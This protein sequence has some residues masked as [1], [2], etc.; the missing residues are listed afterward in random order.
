MYYELVKDIDNIMM[1][2]Q[3]C[4]QSI[5]QFNIIISFNLHGPFPD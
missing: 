1:R 5:K 3:F 2:R 4:M